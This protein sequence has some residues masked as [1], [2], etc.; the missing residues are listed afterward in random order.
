MKIEIPDKNIA[1][2]LVSAFE[3]GSSWAY[4]SQVH[5]PKPKRGEVSIDHEK[6]GKLYAAPF[7]PCGYIQILDLYDEIGKDI[8]GE[9][10]FRQHRLDCDRIQSGLDLMVQN[11]CF[12]YFAGAVSGEAT[13]VESDAFLQHCL[14]GEIVY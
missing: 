13:A 10:L 12:R 7:L 1:S 11:K 6:L 8:D 2:T 5:C 3:G 4:V 14:F 9:V